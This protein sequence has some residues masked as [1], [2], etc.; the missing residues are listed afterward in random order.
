M[1]GKVKTLLLVHLGT[2][3]FHFDQEEVDAKIEFQL[4][5]VFNQCLIAVLF[6]VPKPSRQVESWFCVS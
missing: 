1:K 3:L 5:F 2:N 6:R 4:S